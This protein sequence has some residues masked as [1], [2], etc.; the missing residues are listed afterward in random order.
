MK[1]P[2]GAKWFIFASII[3][4]LS[5]LISL[6]VYKYLKDIMPTISALAPPSA[7]LSLFI[8]IAI[9][10]VGIIAVIKRNRIVYSM[11][12]GL[13]LAKIGTTLYTVTGAAPEELLN[14]ILTLLP[15][16]YFLWYFIMLKQYF[17]A[18]KSSSNTPNIIHADKTVN[19]YLLVYI[20]MLIISTIYVL[21]QSR[22]TGSNNVKDAVKY[23][24]ALVG[25]SF[26]ERNEYCLVLDQ[27]EKDPCLLV[28]FSMTKNLDNITPNHC[29]LLTLETNTIVCY[30]KINR[31]DLAAND[32][33]RDLCEFSKKAFEARAESKK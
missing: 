32:Q 14:T 28:A 20:I 3:N 16:L 24:T 18:P 10:F 17:H 4:I 9:S 12:I 23:A 5:I 29:K 2:Y 15:T 7:Q 30:G 27:K 25:K 22:A 1:I 19:I 11:L 31:C 21:I 8:T 13:F 33:L 6:F 26:R